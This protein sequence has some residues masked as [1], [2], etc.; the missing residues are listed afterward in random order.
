MLPANIYQYFNQDLKIFNFEIPY[1]PD[2]VENWFKVM[3]VNLRL[4]ESDE[5]FSNYGI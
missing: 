2:L 3:D 5:K 4:Y 1:V